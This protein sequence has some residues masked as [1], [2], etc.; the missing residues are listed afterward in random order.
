M[1]KSNDM[2]TEKLRLELS[3]FGNVKVCK[4]DTVF[5]LHMLRD[6]IS[7]AGNM[8]G[9]FACIDKHLKG[10]YSRLIAMYNNDHSLI[11]VVDKEGGGN[12]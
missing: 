5:V 2:D 4:A 11:M 12:D 9:I 3:E 6:K 1:L 10:H 7:E 8:S